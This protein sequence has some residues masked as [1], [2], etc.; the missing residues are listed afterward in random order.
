MGS[1]VSLT[2]SP[3][4]VVPLGGRSKFCGFRLQFIGEY[5]ETITKRTR[6]F[7]APTLCH[8]A[9]LS[10]SLRKAGARLAISS[11]ITAEGRAV[12]LTNKPGQAS[13]PINF[14]T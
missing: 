7:E 11:P 5:L 9:L 12:T 2:G 8:R 4:Q 10:I 13:V 14:R 6:V 1:R 3:E